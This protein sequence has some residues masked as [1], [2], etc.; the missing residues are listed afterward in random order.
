MSNKGKLKL[1]CYSA[2]VSM[3]IV[4]NFP[5]LLFITFREEFGLSFSLL[6]LLVLVN[7]VTQIIVDTGLSFFSHKMNLQAIVRLM[8]VLTVLGLSIYALSPVLLGE[9]V[10]LGLVLG[11]VVFSA[12]SGLGEVLISPIIAALPSPDPDREMSK[13]HS[14]Y[15]W[16]VV[17]VVPFATIFMMLFGR[18]NW[19]ILTAI[20]A[21]IPLVSCVLFSVSTIPCL[22]TGEKTFNVAS[23]L[24]SKGF[25]ACFFA[26]FLGGAAECTMAQWCSSYSESALGIDKVWGD[27]FGAAL[28]AAMLGLGRTVYAKIGKNI[29]KVIIWGAVGSTA[30]YLV[31][32]VS[33]APVAGLVACAL[34]GLCSSMLWPG[35]LVVATDRF[36]KG[37]VFIFAMMAAG[38]DLGAS[39]GPQL[40]GVVADTVIVSEKALGFASELGITA[41]QLGMKA[42]MLSGML[43][44]LAAIPLYCLMH[45]KDK[46][47]KSL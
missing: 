18:E 14:V 4:G 30:C 17:F 25:W 23:Y 40:V 7:F 19:Q 43:F 47:A 37:G 1:A 46:N 38:G 36:P 20:L 8:P 11:T 3:S 39:V 44:P 16:G 42:G 45:K 10:Y 32:A 2:N 12:A 27:I 35:N 29:G 33:D 41:E 5:P 13:L 26:I 6:G 9:Y 34:C 15:A 24:K 28:F 21:V 22:N 31:A